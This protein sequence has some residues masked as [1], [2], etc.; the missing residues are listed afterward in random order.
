MNIF[1]RFLDDKLPD[2][3]EFY[4]FLKDKCIS[5]KYYL[6][7]VNVWNAFKMK[8]GVIIMIFI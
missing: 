4:S 6:Q 8:T 3:S 2:K 1:K 5:E 7:V